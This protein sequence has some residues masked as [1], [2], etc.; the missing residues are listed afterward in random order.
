MQGDK[1]NFLKRLASLYEII[2]ILKNG[3]VNSISSFSFYDIKHR[4]GFKFLF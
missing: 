2:S 1:Y 3:D 4:N